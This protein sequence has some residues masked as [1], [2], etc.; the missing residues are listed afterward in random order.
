MNQPLINVTDYPLPGLLLNGLGCFFWVLSYLVLVRNIQQKKFVQMPAYVACANIGW[1]FVW[2]FIYHPNTGLLYSLS[3]QAAFLLDCYIFYSL[4]LYGNKQPIIE[5]LQKHFRMF[6]L[7][8]FAFWVFFCYFYQGEGFDTDIGA[9]S[10]YIINVILS[11]QCVML[12]LQTPDVREFSLSLAVF[13]MLGTGLISASMFV[14]YPQNHLVQFLGTTCLL[15][16]NLYIYLLWN[17]QAAPAT[18]QK[19]IEYAEQVS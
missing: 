14:F 2:S 18:V 10:G 4:L 7:F 11:M 19:Q 1:E 16:D 12:L 17:R 3:Y 8:N 5:A 6:C 15:F 13:K 9:N